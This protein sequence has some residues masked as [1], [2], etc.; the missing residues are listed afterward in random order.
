MRTRIVLWTLIMSVAG[1]LLVISSCLLL[2]ALVLFFS[3][4]SRITWS[5]FCLWKERTIALSHQL[6]ID[7]A[8]DEV[9]VF[10]ILL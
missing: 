5:C 3:S 7:L 8:Y 1:S 2:Y 6:C 4:S 9:L 10:V